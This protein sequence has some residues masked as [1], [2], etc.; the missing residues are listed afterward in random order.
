M[1]PVV[2]DVWAERPEVTFFC[3][4]VN[5]LAVESI[6]EEFAARE[7]VEVNTVFDGCGILT[8]K[9][10]TIVDQSTARGF[11]DVYMACDVYYLENVK[12]WFQEAANVSDTEIVMVVPKGSTKVKSLDDLLEPG[13][14]VAIGQPEQCTIGALTRGLLE[15]EG[16]YEKL[17][18]KQ[19]QPGETV[20][21]KPSSA[22]LV[23]DVTT[24]NVDVALAYI[25]DALRNRTQVDIIKLESPFRL[26]VQPFSISKSSDH[27][28]LLRR[29]FKKVAASPEA[30]ERAGF[31]FRL[32]KP[33][34]D[35]GGAAPSTDTSAG[36]STETE[37]TGDAP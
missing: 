36:P 3:G 21:E 12:E 24:G 18:E 22:N 4:A 34:A 30:F 17:I 1:R 35:A 11:P 31:N 29:L 33:D 37:P 20:V 19:R 13:I 2:G 23:P 16:V 9:M 6:V 8:G 15:K 32:N 28:Y 10:K 27:K 7:G 26:A 25:T 5:R 14:R